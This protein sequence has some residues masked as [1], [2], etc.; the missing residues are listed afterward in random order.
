M[1]RSVKRATK[2][3]TCFAA[4]HQNE[5]KSDVARFTTHIQTCLAANQ[6]A[7]GCEKLLQKVESSSTFCNKTCTCCALYRPRPKLFCSKWRNSRVW[8]E[9]PRNFIQS[10]VSIHATCSKLYLLEDRFE[11]G[12]WNAQHR[13]STRFAAMLQNR[14]HVF[15][16]RVTVPLGKNYFKLF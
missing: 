16:A 11:R 15:V 9:L 14:S 12:W 8:R 13:Y 4:M 1:L 5:L 7:A 2:T 3:A 6:V 10:K